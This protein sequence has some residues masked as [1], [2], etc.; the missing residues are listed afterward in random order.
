MPT[1]SITLT[2]DQAT[3]AQAAIG[4]VLGLTNGGGAPRP[5]TLAEAKAYVIDRLRALVLQ[6]EK[7]TQV[8]AT[9]D[10]P[11]DPT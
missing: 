7:D 5:A 2:T 3:R 1:L 4:K 8:R 6:Q 11:F 9:P 10:T